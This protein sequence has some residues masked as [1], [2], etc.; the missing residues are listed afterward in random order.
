MLLDHEKEFGV[1]H[2]DTFD[3]TTFLIGQYDR[4]PEAI[5]DVKVRYKGRLRADG[6][7]QV[8]IVNKE[9]EVVKTFNV[10]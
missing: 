3:D 4:L 9:G 1:Y 5:K 10:R 8:Q 6:A 7:D 2:W